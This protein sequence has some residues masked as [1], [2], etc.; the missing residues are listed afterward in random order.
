MRLIS[1]PYTSHSQDGSN[2]PCAPVGRFSVEDVAHL[3]TNEIETKPFQQLTSACQGILEYCRI[4][5]IIVLS[6]PTWLTR[7]I[8]IKFLGS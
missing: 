3:G 7:L 2:F 5:C 4:I 6:A 8:C 1:A